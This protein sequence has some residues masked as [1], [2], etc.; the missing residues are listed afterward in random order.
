M[1]KVFN[2]PRGIYKRIKRWNWP[3]ESKL[4]RKELAI[5]NNWGERLDHVGVRILPG[6]H[7]SPKTEFKKGILHPLWKGGL[8]RRGQEYYD[9]RLKVWERDNF[10]CQRC[11]A[12]NGNGKTIQLEAHHIK[13]F[14]EFPKLRY[15]LE[16]GITLCEECHSIVDKYRANFNL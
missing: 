1:E 13:P 15:E 2:M 5:K 8:S 7:K 9:W 6:E 16:N 14:A 3:E 11:G 4:K 10:T 12:R